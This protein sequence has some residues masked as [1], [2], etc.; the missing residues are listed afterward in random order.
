MQ[1]RLRIEMEAT[2][3]LPEYKHEF[4]AGADV[5]AVIPQPIKLWPRDRVVVGTGLKADIPVGYEIQCRPRSGLA[6]KNGIMIVNSPGTI[7]CQ[8]KDEIKVIL[9]NTSDTPFEINNGDRIAQFVVAPL[10]QG[11]FVKVP[12]INKDNDRGGGIGSTGV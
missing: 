8:Y 2:E 5:R 10:L 1:E 4:D 9:L 3:R 7:D 11:N 6:A 12:S